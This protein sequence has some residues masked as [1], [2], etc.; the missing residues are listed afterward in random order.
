M[1][2]TQIV[3][4]LDGSRAPRRED[5]RPATDP[6]AGSLARSRHADLLDRGFAG[7]INGA[8]G[9]GLWSG[10]KSLRDDL[11]AGC[12]GRQTAALQRREVPA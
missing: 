8:S 10:G 7:H 2:K 6:R 3:P 5:G 11:L 1:T 9:L 4:G 12:A